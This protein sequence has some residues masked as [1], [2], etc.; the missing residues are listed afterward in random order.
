[1]SDP[2]RVVDKR[3]QEGAIA[4]DRLAVCFHT[5]L[6]STL[7]AYREVLDVEGVPFRQERRHESK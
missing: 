2:F 6:P 3:D 1:L 5:H 7:E 4:V